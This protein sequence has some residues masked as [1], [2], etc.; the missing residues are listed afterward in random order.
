MKNL[1]IPLSKTETLGCT[2][3]NHN[4]LFHQV[5]A[6]RKVSKFLTGSTAD[7][8]VPQQEFVCVQCSR[9]PGKIEED[10]AQESQKPASTLSIVQA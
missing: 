4:A 8:F 9:T 6:I 5:F 3:C 7:T 10:N 1:E 2:N